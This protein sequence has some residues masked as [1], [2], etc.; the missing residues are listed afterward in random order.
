[1]NHRNLPIITKIDRARNDLIDFNTLV[2]SS[3]HYNNFSTKLYIGDAIK[4]FCVKKFSLFCQPLPRAEILNKCVTYIIRDTKNGIYYVG[5]SGNAYARLGKH[6]WL[7]E[8]QHHDS[9]RMQAAYSLASKGYIDV[10]IFFTISR[11]EAYNLEESL[12]NEFFHDENMVNHSRISSRSRKGMPNTM[13]SRALQS[14]STLGKKYAEETKKKL[15]DIGKNRKATD[16]T[17]L[18]MS[19]SIRSNYDTEEYKLRKEEIMLEP[20]PKKR[21]ELIYALQSKPVSIEGVVY[22]SINKA[23]SFLN[24]NYTMIYHRVNSIAEIYKNWKYTVP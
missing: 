6:K 8:T 5:S 16:E 17:K 21:M 13:E 14:A 23:M 24:M 3:Q 4:E 19:S 12:L 1:M 2:N 7:L 20:D 10:T 11:D 15:S 18:K 22:P 9:K